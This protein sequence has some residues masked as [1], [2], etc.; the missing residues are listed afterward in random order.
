M[1]GLED[2][3]CGGLVPW[4]AGVPN[5]AWTGSEDAARVAS[6][7]PL[8]KRPVG[9]KAAA[10]TVE[11]LSAGLSTK[12]N[13]KESVGDFGARLGALLRR[14]GQDAVAC[15]EL[16]NEMTSALQHPHRISVVRL[17]EAAE[18][19]WPLCDSCDKVN[20]SAAK[21]ALCDSFPDTMKLDI[22]K[23]DEGNRWMFLQAW[24]FFIRECAP[25]SLTKCDDIKKK[26][27]DT[28]PSDFPQQNLKLMADEHDD[29]AGELE[30]GG[31]WQPNCLQDMMNGCKKAD[32]DSQDR[33]V[34]E[35]KAN[36]LETVLLEIGQERDPN[37]Q[38]QALD[39]AN[40]TCHDT[41][42]CCR[43][44]HLK[45]VAA[46]RHPPAK[47]AVDSKAVPQSFGANLAAAG[48]QFWTLVQREVG[49]AMEA[50]MGGKSLDEKKKHD[51][52]KSKFGKTD[53]KKLD[54]Q[55]QRWNKLAPKPGEPTTIEKN[56]KKHH[57]CEKC[58]R[59]CLSHGQSSAPE[60][61]GH[62]KDREQRQSSH[63]A[64]LPHWKPCHGP[65]SLCLQL[66]L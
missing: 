56:G 14:C 26:L 16:N 40:C 20:D 65:Q 12:F 55:Q 54:Q 36:V 27:R 6:D 30:Q 35:A 1:G 49:E 59:W 9:T 42:E 37:L 63:S 22:Q 21:E 43:D 47:N 61:M 28:K 4:T 13:T 18:Q 8:Q 31:Q 23:K 24:S 51:K 38:D 34:L 44:Q 39:N 52:V 62:S 60:G 32:W 66:L 2:D 15:V 41:K 33:L 58:H 5:A 53:H 46:E 50:A 17:R 19:R 11:K 29:L 3:G 10:C 57:W 25:V 45:A 64:S 48:P 7:N